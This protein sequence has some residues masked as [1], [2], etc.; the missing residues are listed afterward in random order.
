MHRWTCVFL[1]ASTASAQGWANLSG[2]IKDDSGKP[3][4]GACAV[5]AHDT[6]AAHNVFAAVT[7]PNGEY[8]SKDIPVGKYSICVHAPGDAHPGNCQ[9]TTATTATLAA[10][11]DAKNQGFTVTD[12][13]L[14]QL[15]IDD[16]RKLIDAS[17]DTLVGIQ[18][19]TG[20][21]QPMR[22]AK[23]DATGRTYDVAVPKNTSSKVT[24]IS[25][26]LQM[27]DNKG[28]DM[29]SRAVQGAAASSSA[30][31]THITFQSSS[32]PTSP[33]TAITVTGRT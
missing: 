7:G 4:V 19:P 25:K 8:T 2:T 32:S 10:E 11:Q 3:V 22:L 6:I 33:P 16:P 30:T 17:D 31:S 13:S 12:G 21:F 15:R 14:S 1:V 20:L 28:A 26:R 23:S 9:W 24:V 18:L 27:T 29:A 5:A